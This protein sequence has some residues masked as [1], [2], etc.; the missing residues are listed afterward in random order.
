MGAITVWRYGYSKT[1]GAVFGVLTALMFML[2]G[3]VSGLW[4]AFSINIGFLILHAS[5]L[6]IA[7]KEKK[8][9]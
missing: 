4:G 5:N 7:L 1:Q 8:D 9:G 6:K 3:S 2:W